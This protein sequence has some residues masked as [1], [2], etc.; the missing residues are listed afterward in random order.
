MK[1]VVIDQS[2]DNGSPT[3]NTSSLTRALPM[4]CGSSA[5]TAMEMRCSTT[6]SPAARCRRKCSLGRHTTSA[7]STWWMTRST[8]VPVARCKTL[9]ASLSR[10][11]DRRKWQ[12]RTHRW[13]QGAKHKG[14]EEILLRFWHESASAYSLLYSLNFSIFDRVG[15]ATVVCVSVRWNV[16]A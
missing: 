3:Y 16:T 4:R 15:R 10:Y 12:K 6:A 7:S 13:Y 5:T 1:F 8:R 2:L 14:G 9:H 11:D